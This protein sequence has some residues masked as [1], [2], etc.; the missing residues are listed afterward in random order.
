MFSG[1]TKRQ[2]KQLGRLGF[3]AGSFLR[4]T[5]LFSRLTRWVKL[6]YISST[7]FICAEKENDN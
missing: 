3:L 7:V 4:L 6:P 5:D 1:Y 2:G